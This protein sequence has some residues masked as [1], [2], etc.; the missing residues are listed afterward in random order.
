MTL[1]HE[2]RER[3]TQPLALV[4]TPDTTGSSHRRS[5]SVVGLFSGIGGLELGLELAGHVTALQCELL[6][7]ARAVLDSASRRGESG[8]GAVVPVIADVTSGEFRDALPSQI[9]LLAGGFPCQDLSQAGRTAGITGKRSGLI[10]HVLDVLRDRPVAARPRWIL[11]ENVPFMRHLDGGRAMEVVLNGLTELGYSWA[12]REIDALAFGLPQRRRRLFI[13]A[14]APGE[15]DPRDVL[16]AEDAERPTHGRGAGWLHGRACGFYWTEGNRGLGWADDSVPTLK[17]GSGL[18]I[19]SPPAIVLPS[20]KIVVPNIR[21]AE[22]LQGF[23]RGWTECAKDAEGGKGGRIRWHL[24]GNAVAVDVARW[25][26]SQLAL[27]PSEY[28]AARDRPVARSTWP[29]AAW[30]MGAGPIH[31]SSATDWPVNARNHKSLLD[32]LGEEQ[33]ERPPL[34][35]K[36]AKGFLTRFEVSGLLNRD[37]G[38]R[39]QFLA[40]LREHVRRMEKAPDAV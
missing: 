31:A 25:L 3:R 19:P 40:I 8:S 21:D 38:H 14:S 13:V 35:F 23:D 32:I 39:G 26:G 33:V 12:Y 28:D 34:S 9:D 29:R 5:M 36:A 15:N 1:H 24:V 30:R 11:L 22:R 6:P 37:L 17:G 4:T 18:A 20:G 27:P 10:G 7:S 2:I 16:L